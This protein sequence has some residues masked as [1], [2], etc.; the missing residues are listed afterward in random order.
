MTPE[1]KSRLVKYL[2]KMFPTQ[3]GYITTTASQTIL[4]Y[5]ISK[6]Q[7][8]QMGLKINRTIQLLV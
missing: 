2:L 5:T 7:E 1:I 6:I 3:K 8:N 4:K